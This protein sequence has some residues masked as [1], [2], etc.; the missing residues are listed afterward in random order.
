M[1]KLWATIKKDIR[2]LSRDKLGVLFM[3]IMPIIL[4]IVITAIQNSTFELVND[5]KV[6]LIVSN[7][8]K[9]AAG[10][11]LINAIEK[12]GMFELMQVDEQQTDRQLTDRM[13]NKDALLAIIIPA[14]FSSKMKSKAN[15]I[16]SKA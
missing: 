4:A 6:P 5:N 9:G 11:E 2:L 3:F 16:A 12:V 1:Y 15:T 8:D 7:H 14:D 10:K 13:N